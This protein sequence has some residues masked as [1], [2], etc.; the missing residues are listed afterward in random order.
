MENKK[1]SFKDRRDAK[2]CDDINGMAQIL[3]DLKPRRSLSELYINQEFDVTNLVHYLDKL[4]NDDREYKVTYFHAFV[5]AI[6]K[7][8]YNRP[9]LNRFV[10]NRHVYQHNDVTLSYV[11]KVKFEDTAKE[12]MAMLPI[13]EEDNIYT[14]CE[15]V[16]TKVKMVREKGDEGE[17]AN[18][19]IDIL[20]KLPN[21]I[22]VPLVGLFKMFD[23]HDLLPSSLI[24]DNLYYSSMI[25]SNIGTFK[26][27]GIYHNVTDF[28]TCS[29][30]ITMGEIKE[31]L[32]ENGKKKY[33][34]EFG[35]TIDERIADGFYFIK[36]L[37]LLQYILNNPKLLEGKANEKIEF[38]EN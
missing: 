14:I 29:S 23:R 38:E 35:V 8:M 10:Q 37:H 28:G 27:R 26:C 11:M 17:G 7:V 21:I 22:R 9:Y 16:A 4:K 19:A 25:V 31:K 12:I 24:K 15:K 32:D 13:L 36:S 6:G 33:T 1:K 30:L 34:C 20:S 3:L 5:T 2:Y 18:S